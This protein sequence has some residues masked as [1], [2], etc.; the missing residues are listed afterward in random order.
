MGEN[1]LPLCGW[2]DSAKLVRV[3][4]CNRC[5]KCCDPT[6]IPARMEVYRRY[7]LAVLVHTEPCRHFH[8]EDGKGVC[9]IYEKRAEMCRVFPRIPADIEA[10]PECSYRFIWVDGGED[11][12]SAGSKDS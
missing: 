1:L 4:E 12:T 6:T 8:Y 2:V 11:G 7:R 9:S 5:G 3:G 10:L